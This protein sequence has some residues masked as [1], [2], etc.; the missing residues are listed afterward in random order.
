MRVFRMRGPIT[1]CS[2]LMTILEKTTDVFRANLAQ[3]NAWQICWHR[4]IVEGNHDGYRVEI[5]GRVTSRIF[6]AWGSPC[7]LPFW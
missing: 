1:D 6:R 7:D 3:V 5:L 2:S 4:G